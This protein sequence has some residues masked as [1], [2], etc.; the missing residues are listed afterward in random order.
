MGA[1]TSRAPSGEIRTHIT[2]RARERRIRALFRGAHAVPAGG[3]AYQQPATGRRRPVWTRTAGRHPHIRYSPDG[4]RDFFIRYG[5]SWQ[6]NST[7]RRPPRTRCARG[8]RPVDAG[9]GRVAVGRSRLSN[10]VDDREQDFHELLFPVR[11][12]V[13]RRTGRR[14]LPLTAASGVSRRLT[15]STPVDARPPRRCTLTSVRP[16]KCHEGP[17]TRVRPTPRNW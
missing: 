10:D 3:I 4:S 12:A 2:A 13:W 8:T 6:T 16:E 5:T 15:A 1:S 11:C 9:R 14:A 17:P 7:V